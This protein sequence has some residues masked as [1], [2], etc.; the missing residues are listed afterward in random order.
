MMSE[1][2]ISIFGLI[3]VTSFVAKYVGPTIFG[4]IALSLSI[5]QIVQIVAQMGSDVII[6][7][8]IS[9]NTRSG[10]NLIKATIPLRISI[11]II[12]S[13][14]V[15]SYFF[16]KGEGGVVFIFASFIACFFQSLDVYAIYYDASLKSMVNTFVNVLGLSISLSLRWFIAFFSLNIYWLS[17]PIILTSLIPFLIRYIY[18]NKTHVHSPIDSKT[19]K[20]YSFYLIGSG[21]AFVIS[22]ISVAIYTRMSLFM[23]GVLDGKSSVGI[24]SVAATLAGAWSF[25]LYSFITSSLPSIFSEKDD[26]IAER[27]TSNL[28]L[29]VISISIAVIT[30]VAIISK[31]FLIYFYGDAY[32]GAYVPLIILCFATLSSALGTIAARYIAKYSGFSFLSK[33]MLIV[34]ICSLI[35]NYLFIL[36][37]SIE[38]AAIATLITE[39]LSFS[40][41]NYFFRDK[42]VLRM[43]FRMFKFK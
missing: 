38:G 25:I 4:E 6:F 35:L 17:I 21:G 41:F 3:F 2:I 7:K 32:I 12:L 26:Y 24:F 37:W 43:H 15:V 10:I 39:V 22:S 30:V 9:K 42:L 19:R 20:K 40:I 36:K 5:F 14:P 34:A 33:K 31:W 13:L 29:I 16:I 23:L 1:K 18:F 28:N 11:Y 27:K 8:R